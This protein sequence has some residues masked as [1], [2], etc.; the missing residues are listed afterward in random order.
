MKEYIRNFAKLRAFHVASKK[1]TLVKLSII[2]TLGVIAMLV[3]SALS[4]TNRGISAP[5]LNKHKVVQRDTVSQVLPDSIKIV[6]TKTFY[7][8]THFKDTIRWLKSDTTEAVITVDT[9]HAKKRKV[10]NKD[11]EIQ[12]GE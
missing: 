6:T 11:L 4:I 10:N 5:P 8:T 12:W 7:Y 9:I 3:A 1:E 2:V